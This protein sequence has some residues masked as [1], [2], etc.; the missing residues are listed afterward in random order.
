MRWNYRT[1]CSGTRGCGELPAPAGP[2]SQGRGPEAGVRTAQ[3][4][5]HNRYPYQT[6]SIRDKDF[7]RIL[8]S[9]V[10]FKICCFIFF[11]RDLIKSGVVY[12]CCGSGLLIY[13]LDLDL[14]LVLISKDSKKSQKKLNILVLKYSVIYF[15]FVYISSSMEED[16]ATIQPKSFWLGR[17]CHL[18]YVMVA[19]PWKS[20]LPNGNHLS[21]AGWAERPYS[22]CPSRTPALHLLY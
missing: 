12:Q 22:F 16:G 4:P 11:S 2:L 5:P 3:H 20:L 14:D 6:L 13:L 19:I 1:F 7:H 8:F 21:N 15:F 10:I 17:V 18:V 9:L